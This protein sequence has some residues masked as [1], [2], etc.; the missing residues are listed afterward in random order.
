MQLLVL[1]VVQSEQNACQYI[2]TSVK[3]K[4]T[5]RRFVAELL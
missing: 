1:S 4:W 5:E 2:E 3:Q